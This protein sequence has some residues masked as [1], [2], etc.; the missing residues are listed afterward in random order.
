MKDQNSSTSLLLTTKALSL[1]LSLYIYV[2]HLFN[3]CVIY[4]IP[5][6]LILNLFPA[7]FV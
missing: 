7:G 2:I 4:S 6:G 3:K 5:L 1:S